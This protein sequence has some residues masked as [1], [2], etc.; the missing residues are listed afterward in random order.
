MGGK[1]SSTSHKSGYEE[2]N[3]QSTKK[4]SL[5]SYPV[6]PKLT[7]KKK[8]IILRKCTCIILINP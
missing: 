7:L 2:I 8:K 1:K 6:I 4:K 3:A 5:N